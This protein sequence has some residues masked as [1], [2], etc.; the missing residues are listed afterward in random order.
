M[1]RSQTDSGS[2]AVPA[3]LPDVR[4]SVTVPAPAATAFRIYTERAI[5]WLP[6]AHMFI[7]GPQAV[8]LEPYAGGRFYERGHDGTEI[9][10]GTV[11]EWAPPG[12]LV[13]TWRIGPD[14]QPVSDDEQASRISADF[15]PAG[16]QATE[17]TLTYSQLHRHGALGRQLL[18]ILSAPGPGET[19]QRYADL[20]S[21]MA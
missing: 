7:A 18:A 15:R 6:P 12:R 3:G 2:G 16:P 8:T 4:K 5:D 19:L 11:Q 20:V 9:T 13:L 1:A 14:W 21:R 10:R 17:V